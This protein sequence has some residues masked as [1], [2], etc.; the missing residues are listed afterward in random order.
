MDND[1]KSEPDCSSSSSSTPVSQKRNHNSK[2]P[3]SQNLPKLKESIAKRKDI[4]S[5]GRD[6][7]D[8]YLNER[9]SSIKVPTI[10]LPPLEKSEK[11][12]ACKS[13]LYIGNLP[14]K[15]AEEQI[16]DLFK[17]YG[18]I[19]DVF[20]ND[21]KSFA[22]L[23][24]DY[25]FNAFKAKTELNGYILNGRSLVVKFA[26][27]P[28]VLVKNLPV[29]VSDEL[30]CLAFSVFGEVEHCNVVVDSYG[31]PTGKGIVH[32]AKKGSAI[33]AKKRCT[34]NPFFLTSSLKPVIV[35][36]YEPLNDL[37]GYTEKQVSN[38]KDTE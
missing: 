11:K 19:D 30:L 27:I 37:D 5:G 3:K 25:Y 2:F 16:T 14:P 6:R 23:K 21:S 28:S 38:H 12:F 26:Q 29:N 13:R 36:D 10:D 7:D 24:M 17:K 1:L 33:L 22:F 15:A 8:Y 34:E 31:K 4:N 32:F 9:L 18:E 20:I 35:D